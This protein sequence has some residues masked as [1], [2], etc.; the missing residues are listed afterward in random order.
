MHQN[1][2]W[3]EAILSITRAALLSNN[4]RK[5]ILFTENLSILLSYSQN[6]L[7]SGIQRRVLL[8]PQIVKQCT[9]SI[10]RGFQIRD[11]FFRGNIGRIWACKT[12]DFREMRQIY[13]TWEEILALIASTMLAIEGLVATQQES[14]ARGKRQNAVPWTL[15]LKC[16]NTETLIKSYSLI[17]SFVSLCGNKKH[18]WTKPPF[19]VHINSMSLHRHMVRFEIIFLLW[20][21]NTS[22]IGN[23]FIFSVKLTGEGPRLIEWGTTPSELTYSTRQRKENV[24]QSLLAPK[25]LPRK[26]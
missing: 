1:F 22:L 7:S 18:V 16:P 8:L 24:N 19:F 26:S 21:N 15:F 13:T 10:Y 4:S 11:D 5:A 20:M 23:P 12:A 14:K 9:D 17:F 3:K 25:L 2:W 6:L